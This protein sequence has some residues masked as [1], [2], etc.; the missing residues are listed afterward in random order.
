G[1]CFTVHGRLSVYNG[2]PALRIWRVGTKR[3]LGVSEQRF[4]IEGYRNV[5]EEV[6]SKIDQDKALLGDYLVCPFT[7]SRKNEMQL[8][9]IEKVSNLVIEEK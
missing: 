6:R 5:P 8:V 2:A 4:A 7:R 9:C 3:I 1:S